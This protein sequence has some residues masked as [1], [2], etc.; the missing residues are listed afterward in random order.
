MKPV[1]TLLH[2]A[3]ENGALHGGKV[4]GVGDVIRDLPPALAKCECEVHVI[5]PAYYNQNWLRT[6]KRVKTLDVMF[7]GQSLAVKLYRVRGADQPE[8][9]YQWLL[10]HPAFAPEGPGQIY[11]SDGDHGPYATDAQKF[12]LFCTAVAELLL[13]GFWGAM[14]VLHL[15][16]W[17]AAML[18]V[19]RHYHPRYRALCQ[20]PCV[21]TIHN[22]AYQGVRPLRGNESSPEA[23]FPEMRL[24]KD[25][26]DPRWPKCINLMRAGIALADKVHTVSATYAREIL[27][28]SDMGGRGYVGGEGLESD[29]QQA[30]QQGRLV[31]ILNGCNYQ[32]ADAGLSEPLTPAKI[33]E[34][35]RKHLW[36]WMAT[37]PQLPTVHYIAD[38][39]LEALAHSE[40]G[41]LITSVGRVTTQKIR[42]LHQSLPDGRSALAAMLEELAGKGS[43]LM[44]GSGDQ[45]LEQFLLATSVEYPHFIFLRG[46][47]EAAA[48]VLYQCGDLFVMPSSFEPCGISQM[49]AMR[50]G[51]PCLVHSVGGLND[52]VEHSINGFGFTGDSLQT[53]A[54]ALVSTFKS[55]LHTRLKQP[56]SWRMLCQAAEQTR[57][58]WQVSVERYLQELYH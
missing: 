40:P 55:A 24:D 19:L 23:W 20:L 38:R 53:Q 15:H 54:Q 58:T 31:G 4:G 51:Q 1:K 12:A 30:E 36:R 10:D 43:Y 18:L 26:A 29:L 35:L 47:S 27:H 37:E 42:L 52:T 39:R 5:L 22:L 8:G 49:L 25:I 9:V 48:E 56:Q 17:H 7:G 34:Q 13:Q 33:S 6:A 32:P 28:P 16:D 45:E 21:F 3:A 11:C 44:I 14:D 2:V 41:V 57:F 50:A 46:Y